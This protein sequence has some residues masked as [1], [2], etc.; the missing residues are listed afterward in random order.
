MAEFANLIQNFGLAVAILIALGVF[1][2]RLLVW[3]KPWVEKL[4]N[5]H[6]AFVNSTSATVDELK[7]T[8]SELK[9]LHE[10]TTRNMG[11][12]VQSNMRTEQKLDKLVDSSARASDILQKMSNYQN[13]K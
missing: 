10:A 3:I 9:G 6:L 5:A 2:W 11:E 7:Q 13:G 8:V 1:L 12:L 4:V